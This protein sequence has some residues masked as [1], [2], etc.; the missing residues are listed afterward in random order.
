MMLPDILFGL[1]IILFFA[2]THIFVYSIGYK[3]G[4]KQNEEDKK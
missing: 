2:G 1:S 3:H 4:V